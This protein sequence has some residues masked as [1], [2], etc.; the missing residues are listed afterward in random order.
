MKLATIKEDHS[1]PYKG[2]TTL[3]ISLVN[4]GSLVKLSW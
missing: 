3:A 1:K 2:W 4:V